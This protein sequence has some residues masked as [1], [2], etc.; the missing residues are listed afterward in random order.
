MSGPR[1]RVSADPEDIKRPNAAR[2]YD[3]LLGGGH[4][5]AADRRAADDLLRVAPDIVTAVRANRVFLASTVRYALAA[6]IRQVLDLG[7]GLPTAGSAHR[8][9]HAVDPT[10]RV[11]Y[12]DSDPVV[13]AAGRLLARNEHVGVVHADLRSVDTVLAH[14]ETRRLVDFGQPLAVLA[15]CVLHFIPGDLSTIADTLRE[16]ISP[17]SLLA[18]SHATMP[19][20]EDCATK[21]DAV[22][23]LYA[24]TPT[25][26]HFRPRDQIARLLTGL[27]LVPPGVV[28]V[29]A[30][31]PDGH[32]GAGAPVTG[33]LAAV[34][35]KPD[36]L[37][38]WMA[39]V[40]GASRC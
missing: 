24:Q 16:R 23:G 28:P 2:I 22:L 6:G 27:D 5:F 39:D 1:W 29:N 19:P 14:P 20:G 13:T 18:I 38:I 10:V 7:C 17:G 21:A 8:I 15:L 35:R 12:V 11:V 4:N 33:L 40:R 31:D 3:Y 32:R 36:P 37:P 26:L 34:A 25:P 30:W 9:A